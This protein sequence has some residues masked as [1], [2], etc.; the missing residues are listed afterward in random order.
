MYDVLFN[1]WGTSLAESLWHLGACSADLIDFA[2]FREM[3][4]GAKC[5]F[6]HREVETGTMVSLEENY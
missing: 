3:R 1:Q 2:M 6:S 4:E 5:E